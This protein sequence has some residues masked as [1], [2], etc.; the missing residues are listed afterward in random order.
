LSYEGLRLRQPMTA[1]TQVP[2]IFARQASAV[3]PFLKAF[4]LPNGLAGA[5]NFA[6]YA[7]TFSNPAR[8]D[9]FSIRIDNNVT[10]NL[11]LIWRYSFADSTA[12]QR[13]SGGFS[14]NTTNRVQ[15]VSH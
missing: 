11:R 15:T 10:N 7:A 6:E 3:Q 8:H 9:A 1:I 4:P 2:S 13:G 5:D 14:L 12:S